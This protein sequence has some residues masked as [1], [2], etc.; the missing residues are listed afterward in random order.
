MKHVPA[1]TARTLVTGAGGFLGTSLT[2][3]LLA[4]GYTNLALLYRKLPSAERQQEWRRR[5]PDAQID[6]IRG[7][8]MSPSD[9]RS[10]VAGADLIIHVA[11]GM[12]GAPADLA[13]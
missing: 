7:N 3:R 4:H 13:L 5:Y 11:A 8:M 12:R 1:K 9:L 6:F 2:E 10:A